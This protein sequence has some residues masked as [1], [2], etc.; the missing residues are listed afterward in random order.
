MRIGICGVGVVG[1]ACA[2]GF[3]RLGHDI[4]RHDPRLG[5][6]LEELTDWRPDIVFVCVP[7]PAN[8]DG[9]CNV[10]VVEEVVGQLA[11][12]FDGIIVIKS[13]VEPGTTRRLAAK[14]SC[15][16]RLAFVPEFLRERSAF[17]DFVEHHELLVIGVEG[18]D[19]PF[20]FELIKTAH[21][22]YPHSVV[23]L[24]WTEAEL[25][26]YFSN[27]YCAM[28]V[29]FANGFWE[30][31]EALGANYTNVKNAVTK[32]SVID[33]SYLDCNAKWRGYFGPCLPKDCNAFVYLVNKLNIPA[34]I[35][36]A[37]RDD[38]KLYTP[39]VPEGMR[40]N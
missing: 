17:S 34:R 5:T 33:N 25:T 36:H 26:K 4:F 8:L 13:T 32:R 20:I 1:A 18:S 29:M 12:S 27:V 19:A 30:V 14:Y 35:F 2:D 37:I 39:T 22:H 6:S 24:S 38:N 31:C 10:S 23:Q 21:G 3:E 16:E 9:S 7:T 11:T 15:G 40:L 28:K